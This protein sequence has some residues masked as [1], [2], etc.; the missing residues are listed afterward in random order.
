MEFPVP[1]AEFV[2]V[3]SISDS[4]SYQL[5]KTGALSPPTKWCGRGLR[6]CLRTALKELAVLNNLQ[7]P[8]DAVILEYWNSIL[9]IRHQKKMNKLAKKA[10]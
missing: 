8:S 2:L 5:Q 6:F 3:C 10:K 7:P 4:Q 9:Q 1:R